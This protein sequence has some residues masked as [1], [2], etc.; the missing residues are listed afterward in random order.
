MAEN[1]RVLILGE[2]SKGK[3]SAGTR[4][5]LGGGRDLSDIL[6][7]MLSLILLGDGLKAAGEESI[8]Y[9]AD[10]VYLAENPELK[11]YQADAYLQILET[12][13]KNINPE[14]LLMGQTSM[15]RDLAPQLAYRFKTGIAMDC[16]HL[17]VEPDPCLLRMTRPVYGCK[18]LA[19]MTCKT[20][21]QMATVRCGA[22]KPK[23][24]D[25]SRKGKV[26]VIPAYIDES[27][28]R[29]QV[30]G[31]VEK[32]ADGI[33]LEIA[34]VVI[35]GGRG[36]GSADS[37]SILDELAQLLGGTVGASRPPCDAGWISSTRQIGLTGKIVRP[38]LYIAVALS[39]SSQHMAGCSDSKV[40]VAINKDP[41]ANIFSLAHYGIVGDYRQILPPFI[42]R[43]RQIQESKGEKDAARA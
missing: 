14:I 15:G 18:A 9:G 35:C 34:Q 40:I 24:P 27:R 20:K 38:D 32:P 19:V 1:N 11:N 43:V 33:P 30:L 36:M 21:P 12:T 23:E 22:M 3:L 28:V 16:V 6:G 31:K 17:D 41:E 25:E 37:F 10:E 29:T 42:R 7:G 26:E 4:E 8:A 13:I 2:L 5:L 39:G